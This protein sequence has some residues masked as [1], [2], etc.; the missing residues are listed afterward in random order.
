VIEIRRA[1]GGDR[2]FGRH[3]FIRRRGEQIAALANVTAT[4]SC[5]HACVR[6]LRDGQPTIARLL[7]IPMR[8]PPHRLN[9]G[10]GAVE[11]G[12]LAA[13]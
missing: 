12:L 8:K 1:A 13:A 9:E 5:G 7:D 11:G 4:F 6:T 3:R 10:G 2:Q